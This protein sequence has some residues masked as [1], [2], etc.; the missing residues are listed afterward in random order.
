MKNLYLID[1]THVLKAKIKGQAVEIKHLKAK[2]RK[3]IV[4]A[5]ILATGEDPDADKIGKMRTLACHL[6]ELAPRRDARH[7]LLAYAFAR[8]V[9]YKVAENYYRAGNAPSVHSISRLVFPLE[10]ERVRNAE[11]GTN[12]PW[13]VQK[14]IEPISNWLVAE[15][16]KAAETVAAIVETPVQTAQVAA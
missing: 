4:R 10:Y 11:Q 15:P 12:I 13:Y 6:A 9:P 16:P 2:K 8:D 3:M 5:R 14:C 7:T 1:R